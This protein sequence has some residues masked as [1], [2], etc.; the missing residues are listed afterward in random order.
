VRSPGE[1][2]KGHLP[3]AVNLPL[4]ED[5]E[6]AEI[7]TL[8][9]RQSR[10]KA[11][12]RGLELVG[13][14]MVRFIRTVNQLK[15]SLKQENPVIG[16]YCWRGGMRSNSMAWLLR[17]YGF[18]VCLL[19]GGYKAYR[20]GLPALLEQYDWKFILLGGLTG[21]GK[22]DV[23]NQMAAAGQQI[24]DLEGLANHR[25]SAFGHLGQEDQPTT[26]TF[27]NRIHDRLRLFNPANPVWIEAESQLIGSVHIP[28]LLFERMKKAPIY[29]YEIPLQQRIERLCKEY[30]HFNKTELKEA[31]GKITKRLGVER[32]RIAMQMIDENKIAE[33]AELA[34]FYYDKS[35]SHSLKAQK[36][37]NAKKVILT[38][39]DPEQAARILITNLYANN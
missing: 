30:G 7:G 14:K 5:H 6:R 35:Y 39:D 16:V 3:N 37:D 19:Q 21:C 20:A 4:F 8:Y 23:L 29:V 15:K 32:A 27:E 17:L 12:E 2:K 28:N 18:R 24:L 25:G 13:P 34:L 36:N 1:F 22:T 38:V 9:I 10:E 31:F 33:A 11:I 26:E